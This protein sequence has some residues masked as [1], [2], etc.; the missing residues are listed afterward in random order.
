MVKP[1]CSNVRVITAKFSD[2]RIFRSFTV[3]NATFSMW[4]MDGEPFELRKL[5]CNMNNFEKLRIVA[6]M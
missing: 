6:Y 1:L 2:V 3:L 5:E 4:G